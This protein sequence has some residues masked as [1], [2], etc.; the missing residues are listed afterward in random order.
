MKTEHALSGLLCDL[1]VLT[2]YFYVLMLFC[3]GMGEVCKWEGWVS[4][5]IRTQFKY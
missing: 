2:L 1:T 5:Q 4:T 3:G